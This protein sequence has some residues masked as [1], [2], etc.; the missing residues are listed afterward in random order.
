MDEA[1]FSGETAGRAR[2]ARGMP[3]P[4]LLA[5]ARSSENPGPRSPGGRAS[6]GFSHQLNAFAVTTHWFISSKPPWFGAGEAVGAGGR[7]SSRTRSFGDQRKSPA[8]AGQGGAT[9]APS[10]DGIQKRAGQDCAAEIGGGKRGGGGGAKKK[11][12][13]RRRML[14]P[15][16]SAGGRSV[17]ASSSPPDP[18][19]IDP[20]WPS[21]VP[22][23]PGWSRPWSRPCC[24][25]GVAVETFSIS[26]GRSLPPPRPPALL[27]MLPSRWRLSRR[28]RFPPGCAR[29]GSCWRAVCSSPPLLHA[30]VDEPAILRN[31]WRREPSAWS[32]GGPK[33]SAWGGRHPPLPGSLSEVLMAT[34]LN[35]TNAATG[36]R[37]P[38]V[39]VATVS[40]DRFVFPAPTPGGL[41]LR[42]TGC[43]SA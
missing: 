7:D 8:Q 17:A 9:A 21:P 23:A 19:A 26:W 12:K 42:N 22:P 27:W 32:A 20:A 2:Q 1:Y 31:G 34:A 37:S 14:N 10:D 11:K 29:V 4:P 25:A 30:L 36:L 13:R 38:T 3:A 24:G 16:R 5:T 33:R 18:L 15:L 28:H 39:S 40:G 41:R 35:R 6:S 43:I